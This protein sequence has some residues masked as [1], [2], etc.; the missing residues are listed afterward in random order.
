[1]RTAFRAMYIFTKQPANRT[2]WN[3]YK[4]HFAAKPPLANMTCFN[5]WRQPGGMKLDGPRFT[6]IVPS[7][8]VVPEFSSFEWSGATVS[9]LEVNNNLINRHT[10]YWRWCVQPQASSSSPVLPPLARGLTVVWSVA[11]QDTFISSNDDNVNSRTDLL[12]VT[13]FRPILLHLLLVHLLRCETIL[14]GL[15]W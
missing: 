7:E 8:T 6:I 1:M 2:K 9:R 15:G 13:S 14:G 4:A 10:H 12:M 5:N 11:R 3:I